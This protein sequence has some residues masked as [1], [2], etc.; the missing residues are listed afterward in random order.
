MNPKSTSVVHLEA[1]VGN[2]AMDNPE[3]HVRQITGMG[4]RR[5]QSYRSCGTH[6]LGSSEQ[7]DIDK[8]VAM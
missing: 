6:R 5:A 1:R 2:E 4:A 8:T 7:T 3:S